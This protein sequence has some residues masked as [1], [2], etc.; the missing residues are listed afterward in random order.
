MAAFGLVIRA[1]Q[2]TT[3]SRPVDE[4]LRSPREHR[5]TALCIIRRDQRILTTGASLAGSFGG[6]PKCGTI[7]SYPKE[8]KDGRRTSQET[9]WWH[10]RG[11]P[12]ARQNSS[13]TRRA[14]YPR[15]HSCGR[16]YSTLYSSA[17]IRLLGHALP[18]LFRCSSQPRI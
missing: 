12:S 9:V 15:S 3:H 7:I 1:N 11:A 18:P 17:T 6:R 13:V 16:R 2:A 8:R 14:F 4:R 5:R 10:R